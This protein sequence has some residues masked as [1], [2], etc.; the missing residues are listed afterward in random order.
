MVVAGG[1]KA[2]LVREV[3]R[4]DT[5]FLLYVVFLLGHFQQT[6]ILD[7]YIIERGII[8]FRVLPGA[9]IRY[10]IVILV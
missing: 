8:C 1:D 2:D 10:S 6:W 3:L 7:V 4:F 9:S 5:S